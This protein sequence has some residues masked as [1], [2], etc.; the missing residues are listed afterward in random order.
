MV[1]RSNAE[2]NDLGEA[3]MLS[4]RG[5]RALCTPP[6]G[7]AWPASSN[8][9]DDKQGGLLDLAVAENKLS[10]DILGKR[11]ALAFGNIS[12]RSFSYNP[13]T[14][15]PSLRNTIAA[16]MREHFCKDNNA[17]GL[18]RQRSQLPH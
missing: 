10:Q 8:P 3:S 12:T 14:G 17:S 5:K 7:M 15:T 2:G 11:A 1:K 4:K 18:Q 16:F 9:L 13:W 6:L